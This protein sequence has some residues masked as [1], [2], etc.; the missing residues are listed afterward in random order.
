MERDQRSNRW[1]TDAITRRDLLK[2]GAVLGTSLLLTGCGDDGEPGAAQEPDVAGLRKDKP[3][4]LVVRS[5][6]DPWS[7]GIERS[8]G[9]AFMDDHGIEI[10][11][12]TSDIGEIQTKVQQAIDSGQRPPV[13]VVYTIATLAEKS[14]VQELVQPLDIENIVTNWDQLSSV[15]KP[16]SGN[17]YVHVYSYTYT[18]IFLK[19][20]IDPGQELSWKS[21]IEDAEYRS[22]FHMNAS[23]HAILWPFARIAGIDP[24]QEDV[25]P[26]WDMVQQMR[27]NICGTGQDVEFIEFLKGGQCD[28]GV[29][30]V[31]DA[32]ALRDAGLEVD[33]IVPVEGVTLTRDSMYVPRGLPENVDFWAQTFLNY[34]IDARNL[35]EW[36][37]SVATVPTNSQ[38]EVRED[39]QGDPAFP[40]TEEEIER[41][42]IP[43]PIDVAAR[44]DDDWQAA[45][46]AALQG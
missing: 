33:W 17:S 3:E 9:K 13:D 11:F 6:G 2:A 35:T 10:E 41:Y 27:P 46:T 40:F 12:D 24:A 31:G 44:N 8:A 1:V 36:C 14:A 21:I 25:S 22:S 37:R 4:K 32:F 39:L 28:W 7:T 34:V 16:E 43:E 30:L 38:S 20:K 42:A 19:D 18:P 15:G 23:Y 45:Y 29:A 5:W 26:V